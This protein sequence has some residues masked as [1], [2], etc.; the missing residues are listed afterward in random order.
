M[1]AV[2]LAYAG[3]TSVRR[4]AVTA[5]IAAP[6]RSATKTLQLAEPL[7]ATKTLQPAETKTLQPTNGARD[8]IVSPNP[9]IAD[10]LYGAARGRIDRAAS[11]ARSSPSWPMA[12]TSRRTSCRRSAPSA[13]P[14]RPSASGPLHINELGIGKFVENIRGT[15]GQIRRLGGNAQA[16][17][18]SPLPQPLSAMPRTSK[19]GGPLPYW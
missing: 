18:R 16:R 7:G 13:L 17:G 6:A 19:R 4:W 2:T 14:P 15:G 10:R 11:I 12:A 5:P 9:E 3:D 8:A 1:G